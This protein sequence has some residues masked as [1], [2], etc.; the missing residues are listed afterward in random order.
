[1]TNPQE[2][3]RSIFRG[4]LPDEL[5]DAVARLRS[6][7]A[8]Q[9]LRAS[10]WFWLVAGL[11]SS[12]LA[13]GGL[14]MYYAL[15]SGAGVGLV[16]ALIFMLVLLLFSAL[17]VARI[18]A[19]VLN[20]EFQMRKW[21]VR[22]MDGDLAARVSTVGYGGEGALLQDINVLG[23]MI[24]R[25]CKNVDQQT[26]VQL[27]QLAQKT[28]SL[29]ILY[30][31]AAGVDVLHDVNELLTRFLHTLCDMVKAR[32]GVV[33]LMTEDGQMRL[34]ATVGCDESTLERAVS[35]EQCL[36]G[37]HAA[38]DLLIQTDVQKC[39]PGLQIATDGGCVALVTIP[40]RY[41]DRTLGVYHLVL[42]SAALI[43]REDVSY[44]F[45]SIGRHLGIAIEKARL[46]RHAR[47]LSIM[48]ER[49]LLANELHDSLAQTL[50]SLRFQV[51][52]VEETV[53]QSKDRTGIRQIRTI[54]EG[55]D[56]ANSQLRELLAHFRTRMDER[57]LIPAIESVVER[58]RKETGIAAYFQNEIGESH[59]PPSLEVQVLHIVQ[60]ALTNVRKHSDAQNVRVLLR[61]EDNG[62]HHVLVEDDGQ[63]I[64]ERVVSDP[65]G[66]HIGLSIMRERA[67]RLGGTLNIESETGEGTRV[68][69]QFS[70][71][72]PRLGRE[73]NDTEPGADST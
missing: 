54:K 46:E 25:M 13:L 10:R 58:F 61:T 9:S 24:S 31:A 23:D 30:D 14:A 67:A 8:P 37:A 36:S 64:A 20:A 18:R 57:G 1:M 65:P 38:D 28:R 53:A 63:G 6:L 33:R 68:E 32:A 62:E 16:A 17:L 4:P 41:S 5:Q 48:E 49:T 71:Q 2:T 55:L 34:I 70:L 60:E 26:R 59:L 15:I 72:P 3:S 45:S 21:I 73:Q 7:T 44:L 43:E 50:A 27:E 56:Q 29:E 51:T 69:L 12:G 39:E 11:T 52:L 47:R 40:I 19:R 42:E 66:E 35:L 22:M